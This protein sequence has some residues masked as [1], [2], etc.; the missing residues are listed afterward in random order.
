MSLFD[1]GQQ[2]NVQWSA[3]LTGGTT[4][5]NANGSAI[6]TA[7]FSG[8]GVALVG[9]AKGDATGAINV[10]N[11]LRLAFREGDDTNVANAT[12]LSAA[13]LVKTEDLTAV[14]TVAYYSIRPTKRYVFPEV[15]KTNATSVTS[16]VNVAIVGVL[17]FPNNAPTN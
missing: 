16:N 2:S 3:L 11:A 6:D 14:N 7:T 15:Y 13:N 12:R 17:G 10:G 5:A 9:G 4:N 1:F 8:V